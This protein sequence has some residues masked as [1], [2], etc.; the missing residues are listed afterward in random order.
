M[1]NL[2]KKGFTLVELLAVIVVLALLMVVAASSIGSAL[3]NSKK[4]ALES[5]AK[6]LLTNIESEARSIAIIKDLPTN[7]SELTTKYPGKDGDFSYVAKVDEDGKITSLK[8]CYLDDYYI[9]LTSSGTLPD[10]VTEGDGSCATPG[11]TV[12]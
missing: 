4:G 7:I 1:R 10:E 2:N 5:E 6:K 3:D 9:E 11:V 8:V 12:E